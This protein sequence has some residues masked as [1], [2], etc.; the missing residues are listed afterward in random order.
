MKILYVTTTRAE[1]GIMEQLLHTLCDREVVDLV[2]AGTHLSNKFGNTSKYI[3]KS[4]YNKV[5]EI[6]NI[7]EE[8]ISVEDE[9]AILQ[10]GLKEVFENDYDMILI[11]GD[12]YEMVTVAQLA[13]LHCIPICHLHGGEKTIG[14]NDDNF[15][16]AITKMSHLHLAST[17]LHKNRIKQLGEENIYNIGS[18]SLK[19]KFNSI[20][21]K[22]L[23]PFEPCEYYVILYHPE[24]NTPGIVK[25]DSNEVFKIVK[26][27]LNENFVIIGS[28]SDAGN[29]L[30][31]NEYSK[32]KDKDNVIISNSFSSTEYKS[33]LKNS[34]GLIGNSSSGLIEAPSLDIP[35]I[36]IGNRQKGRVRG[37]SVFDCEAKTSKIIEMLDVISNT[38][39]EHKNPYT[40]NISVGE[41]ADIIVNFK[42][43]LN[44]NFRDLEIKENVLALIPA[45]SGS[46][47]FPDKNIKRINGKSLIEITIENAIKSSV[48]TNIYLSTDSEKYATITKDYNIDAYPLRDETI[49]SD[50]SSMLDV[51]DDAL[52]KYPNTNTI[53]LL[54]PTSPLRLPNHIKEAYTLFT[55]VE[56]NVVSFTKSE[57]SSKLIKTIENEDISNYFDDKKYIRQNYEEYYPNGAIFVIDAEEYKI[58]RNVYIQGSVPYYMDK[59]HSI[60]IDD[61]YDYILANEIYIRN[62]Y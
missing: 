50:E 40:N 36:N 9:L 16:H 51:I 31:R 54:Q 13:N 22:A 10:L 8:E 39:I 21:I 30:V 49:A 1:Y 28:N 62:M 58:N 5:Y 27:L 26:M 19:A 4:R 24:T 11:L 17:E 46:K 20:D 61:E 7:S 44:K 45:R 47:G 29:D 33:I 48:F 25:E 37:N 59:V 57:K 18:L 3:D 52:E 32:Y 55:S 60:D 14:N 2:I 15:R 42:P 6:K 12:R 56:G 34:K 23:I 43:N 35:T 38:K 41:V 53:V